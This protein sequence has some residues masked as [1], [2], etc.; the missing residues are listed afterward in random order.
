[1]SHETRQAARLERRAKKRQALES[2]LESERRQTAQLWKELNLTRN[3]NAASQK[4]LK[5]NLG[6]YQRSDELGQ[7][8]I[9]Q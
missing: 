1:M 8:K 7:N 2:V 5:Q 3:P 6:F 9:D 4:G